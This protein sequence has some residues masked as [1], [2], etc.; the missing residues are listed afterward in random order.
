MT[1]H[2]PRAKLSEGLPNQKWGQFG[3]PKSHKTN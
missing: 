3:R 2:M 1:Y